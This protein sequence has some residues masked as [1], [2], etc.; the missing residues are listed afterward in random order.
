MSEASGASADGRRCE[1]KL[2]P[3]PVRAGF[4]V[5]ESGPGIRPEPGA[6]PFGAV[7]E[8]AQVNFIGLV[9]SLGASRREPPNEYDS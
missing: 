3:A 1:R 2:R 6:E 8:H 7:M 9:G 5:L 4:P